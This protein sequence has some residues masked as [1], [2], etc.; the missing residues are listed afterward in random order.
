MGRRKERPGCDLKPPNPLKGELD[1]MLQKE[2][3]IGHNN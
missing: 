3:I 1:I 2:L